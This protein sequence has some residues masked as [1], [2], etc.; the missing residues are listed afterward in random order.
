MKANEVKSYKRCP[1]CAS[2]AVFCFEVDHFCTKC[3][4]NTM[5]ADVMSGAFERRM[6]LRQRKSQSMS[7]PSTVRKSS[8]ALIEKTDMSELIEIN[9]EA[10]A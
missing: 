7:S 6:G 2:E 9:D 1:M 10:V 4:W 5:L 8:V 3:D